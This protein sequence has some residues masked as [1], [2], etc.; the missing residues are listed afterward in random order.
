M[1]DGPGTFDAS[2]ALEEAM[3]AGGSAFVQGLNHQDLERLA[4]DLSELEDG[5]SRWKYDIVREEIESR[6]S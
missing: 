3:Q 4:D 5:A 1:S 6:R 2:A